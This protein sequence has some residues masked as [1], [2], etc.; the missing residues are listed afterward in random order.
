VP[1][2]TAPVRRTGATSPPYAAFDERGRTAGVNRMLP[3]HIECRVMGGAQNPPSHTLRHD[4]EHPA[5]RARCGA[6]RVRR[7][8][9]VHSR[10]PPR[11]RRRRV[12]RTDR[13]GCAENTGHR[14]APQ[15]R[16]KTQSGR[17]RNRRCIHTPTRTRRPY[18]AA[19]GAAVS[20]PTIFPATRAS[21]PGLH[22]AAAGAAG[23]WCHA[24]GVSGVAGRRFGW[25]AVLW[26]PAA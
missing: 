26:S 11:Q 3:L 25:H 2:V 20:V 24:C 17:Y 21:R 8:F 9:T 15:E 4:T 18:P 12:A 10:I 5:V 19:A 22:A 16:G 6:T 23:S 1:S 13:S 14:S 7:S